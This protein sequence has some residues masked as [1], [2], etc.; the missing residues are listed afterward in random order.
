MKAE[1]C[2]TDAYRRKWKCVQCD[3]TFPHIYCSEEVLSMAFPTAG[4]WKD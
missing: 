1:A 3:S 2:S 4:S